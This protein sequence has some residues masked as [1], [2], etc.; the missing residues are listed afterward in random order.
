MCFGKGYEPGLETD[1][2]L[3]PRVLNTVDSAKIRYNSKG[4]C[5]IP[6]ATRL[7]ST[8][9]TRPG[10]IT[11]CTQDSLSPD[12]QVDGVYRVVDGMQLPDAER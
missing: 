9:S 8:N 1:L 3:Y 6:R 10:M 4:N 2:P 12:A 7:Q 11:G 5:V